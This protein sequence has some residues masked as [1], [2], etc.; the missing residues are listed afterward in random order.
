MQALDTFLGEDESLELA[1][2][3]NYEF[4]NG[5]LALTNQRIIFL[6][7]HPEFKKTFIRIIRE[8]SVRI[9]ELNYMDLKSATIEKEKL[10]LPLWSSPVAQKISEIPEDS[11]EA[12]AAFLQEKIR[13]RQLD[14]DEYEQLVKKPLA[15]MTPDERHAVY[16]HLELETGDSRFLTSGDIEHLPD[17]MMPDELLIWFASGVL[18]STGKEQKG[19]GFSVI[20]LTDRRILI[21]DKRVLGGVQTISIDLDKI[22]AISGDTGAFWN[23]S[24]RIQDGGDERKISA[25]PNSTIQP[26]VQR[27]Q[28]AIQERKNMFKTVNAAPSTQPAQDIASQLERLADLMDRGILTSEEFASQ[29]AKILNG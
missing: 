10:L 2:K 17:A 7:K 28:E 27:V 13:E 24:I 26:F 15:S 16:R 14:K 18:S 23:G 19:G 22:N 20:A 8:D 29:K 25:V 12:V 9:S 21:I 6:Y 1:V 5:V 3:A 11:R 4:R